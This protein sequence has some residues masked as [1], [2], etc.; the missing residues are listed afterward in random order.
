[1]NDLPP[2]TCIQYIQTHTSHFIRFRLIWLSFLIVIRY[3]HV[4]MEMDRTPCVVHTIQLVVHMLQKETVK[5]VLDKARSVVKLFRKSSVATQRVLDQCGLI[6]VNDCPTR[7][8]ST[9]N[10]VTRLLTVKDAVCQIASDMGWDSLLTSEW[11]N[12]FSCMNYCCLLRNT[13]KP[14]RVTPHLCP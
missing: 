4:D 7:W 8:P 1:M 13:L 6:V 9:F 14:S 5:R 10:M 11:Q 2:A 12:L 3:H